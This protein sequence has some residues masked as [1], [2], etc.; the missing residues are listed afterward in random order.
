MSSTNYAPMAAYQ[1]FVQKYKDELISKAYTG[2]PEAKAF[3][4]VEGLKGRLTL[5][6]LQIGNLAVAWKKTFEPNEVLDFKPRDLDVV[7][8]KVELQI[9]AQ[10]LEHTYAGHLRKTGQSSDDYPYERYVIER[11]LAKLANE[12]AEAFWLGVAADPVVPGTTLLKNTF[13]GLET[14]VKKAI[15][16][17]TIDTKAVATPGDAVTEANILALTES[18]FDLVDPAYQSMGITANCSMNVMRTYYRA[19]RTAYDVTA[20]RGDRGDNTLFLD[21]GN[22][23]II[24]WAGMGDSDRII[25][26]PDDNIYYGY[27]GSKDSNTFN[28]EK[29]HRAMDFWLD[30]MMGV[31]FGRL[32]DSGVIVANS[33]STDI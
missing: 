5:T 28:F 4:N 19:Y 20:E 12:Q 24:G 18:M 9:F 21:F 29:N 26:T 17:N 8:N 31:N 25:I 14:I 22:L 2:F 16:A 13:D 6:E 33:F 23:K 32:D 1:D 27:D 30:F 11:S 10:E 15:I 7:R 3:N